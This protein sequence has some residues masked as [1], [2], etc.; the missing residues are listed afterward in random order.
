MERT[1]NV[2][3]AGLGYVGMSIAVLL[4][5]RHRVVAFDISPDRIE[6]VNAGRATVADAEMEKVLQEE[7]LNLQGTLDPEAAFSGADFIIVGAP[8]NYD[9]RAHYF[10]TSAV[11]S[12]IRQAR[13]ATN[14]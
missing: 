9:E 14:L 3:V 1:Y 13:K 4:A 12:V 11:E 6:K 10:D 8:T 2:T 7:Q 5:R